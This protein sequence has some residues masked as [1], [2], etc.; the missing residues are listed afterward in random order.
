M[1]TARRFELV[2]ELGAG[3][4]GTV[5]LAELVS[6]GDFRRKVALK[7]LNEQWDPS[8]DAGRR[9]RD[10][11]RLL[12]RLRHRNIVQVDDLVLLGGRW[13]VVMEHI[14]G[15]DLERLLA[16][17][18]RLGEH[19]SPTAALELTA[20]V[21]AALDAAWN[22]TPEGEEPLRVVHRD[23]KPSNIRLT[24]EGD[25]KVLDFGI[26]RASFEG[27]ESKTEQVRYGSLGYMAPER[28]LGDPETPAGDVYGMGCVLAEMLM[29]RTFGRS[30]LVPDQ[31]VAHVE[32]ALSD[33]SRELGERG[34]PVVT[35][36][37][38]MLSY[39]ADERPGATEVADRCRKLARALEGEDLASFCQRVV[40]R[41]NAVL[42]DPSREAQGYLAEQSVFDERSTMAN[43]VRLPSTSELRSPPASPTLVVPLDGPEPDEPVPRKTSRLPFV[44]VAIGAIVA[45]VFGTVWGL[46]QPPAPPVEPA[47]PYVIAPI[48]APAPPA[49]VAPAITAPAVEAPTAP[50]APPTAVAV[51]PVE[52]ARASRQTVSKP[53]VAPAEPPPSA[54]AI[55]LPVTTGSTAETRLRAVK[56]AV[57]TATSVQASCGDVNASG[58]TSAL[59]RDAPAGTCTVTAVVDGVPVQ[60]A[61]TVD[62]PKGYTCAVEEGALACR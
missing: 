19:M 29:G 30:P 27:R 44:F 47:A 40:P 56:F 38:A 3:A 50:P 57:A 14:P 34:A 25:V 53:P 6:T 46:N 22:S 20:A 61:I 33:V 31:Q 39:E 10:E 18:D 23:I 13:A 54:T 49:S 42:G 15:A 21:A 11:A 43:V 16:T 52:T 59:L 24:A 45:F 36:L 8:G 32:A 9:L 55:E 37:R 35:L 41:V 4:F 17:V 2:R 1:T 7:L 5:Y 60:G 48:D 51:P 26:A 62:G 28:L 58:T 12:G